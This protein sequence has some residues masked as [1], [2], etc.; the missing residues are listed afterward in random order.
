MR[1]AQILANKGRDVAT[2]ATTATIHAAAKELA[3]RKIGALVVTDDGKTVAGILSERDVVRLLGGEAPDLATPVS[4]VMTSTVHTCDDDETVDQLM[5]TMTERRIRHVPV[6]NDGALSG[7]VSIGDVV[8][9]RTQEL[10]VESEALKDY[11]TGSN[12]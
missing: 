10:E 1:V 3:R 5:I 4:Q 12:Y 7:M 6:V 9:Q 2:I 8:K 11:V